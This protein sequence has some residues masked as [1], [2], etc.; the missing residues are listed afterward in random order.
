VIRPSQVSL[1]AT[2]N[3]RGVLRGGLMFSKGRRLAYTSKVNGRMQS[4]PTLLDQ[5]FAGTD[6]RS[7]AFGKQL[8]V[9]RLLERL[10][11]RRSV[12]AQRAAVI[13][14]ESDQNRLGKIGVLPEVLADLQRFDPADREIDDDAIGMEALGLNA[15]FEAAGGNAHFERAFDGQLTLQVFD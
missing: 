2:K 11:D 13:G 6:Q 12:E 15:S 4:C 14:Q 7:Q 10:V 8:A 3:R 9:E 5:L 1:E